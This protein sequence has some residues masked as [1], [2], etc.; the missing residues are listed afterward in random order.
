[1]HN[2][3]GF[4]A[5]RKSA[6]Q[7][8]S[9]NRKLH[10][11]LVAIL[12][13]FAAITVLA[14]PAA[15]QFTINITGT[16][17]AGSIVMTITGTATPANTQNNTDLIANGNVPDFLDI[18]LGFLFNVSATGGCSDSDETL[19]FGQ[20]DTIIQDQAGAVNDDI[21]VRFTAAFG[22]VA[23]DPV[24]CNGTL[25]F[26]TD[27][28][29]ILTVNLPVTFASNGADF[30]NVTLQFTPNLAV[31]PE[32]TQRAIAN[33][34]SRRADQITANEPDLASRLSRA[35]GS[36][37]NGPVNFTANGDL[38]NKVVAF[39]TSFRQIMAAGEKTRQKRQEDLSGMMA[40]GVQSINGTVVSNTLDVWVQGKWVQFDSDAAES[41]LGLL[42]VGA[43]YRLNSSLLVGILA[44][45]DW[46]NEEDDAFNSDIEGSGWMIGPYFVARLHQNLL[47]DG[48]AAWG[49]SDND[50]SPNGTFTDSFDTDRWLVKGQLT[51]D[52]DY[53]QWHFAPH[54][55]VLYFEDSQDAYT[56]SL[57][58]FIGEQTVSLGRVIFGPKVTTRFRAGNAVIFPY[59]G[60][61]GIWDFDRNDTVDVAT[62]LAVGTDDFRGRVEGGA[63][64]ALPSDI[65]L[66]SE[67]FYDGIGADDFD[68][69]GGSVTLRVPLN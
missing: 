7:W 6:F 10:Q 51:G 21:A 31:S 26:N 39:S 69:Y 11:P 55:S 24:T 52:F 65:Y 32:Q 48:R 18:G 19:L 5:L 56:D 38:D 29:T 68:A 14:Q 17:G 58:S 2:Y 33:F 27:I 40:L 44:Q 63:S 54:V 12:V 62:G 64:I 61:K 60:I 22:F 50:I 20:T 13:S 30:G 1:M 57:G 35:T 34:L 67:G 53:G 28:N 37:N 16:P 25:T 43:D 8:R 46:T 66:T 9:L 45:F 59:F 41:D 49:R 36:G 42:H 47:F 23:G 15:A 4:V 3:K